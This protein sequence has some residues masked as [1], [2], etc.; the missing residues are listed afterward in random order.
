MVILKEA[1]Q[2]TGWDIVVNIST[3]TKIRFYKLK[4]DNYFFFKKKERE[5]EKSKSR[6]LNV[7]LY[8]RIFF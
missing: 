2:A 5:R 4:R 8:D 7:I 3:P 1:G 6:H